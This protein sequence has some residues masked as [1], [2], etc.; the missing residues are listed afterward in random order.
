VQVWFQEF[1]EH[2]TDNDE[3]SL[4]SSSV[5]DIYPK[6]AAQLTVPVRRLLWPSNDLLLC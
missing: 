4:W 3:I 6:L 5:S 1:P 2:N